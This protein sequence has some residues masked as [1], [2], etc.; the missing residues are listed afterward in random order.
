MRK[1]LLL[2]AVLTF[3]SPAL[4]RSI[5]VNW[6]VLD[7]VDSAFASAP[8][9]SDATEWLRRTLP[10]VEIHNGFIRRISSDT[11]FIFLDHLAE[12]DITVIYLP[13]DPNG[14]M[15]RY[16]PLSGGRALVTMNARKLLFF[17]DRHGLLDR[18][19]RILRHEF[20]HAIGLVA[21]KDHL[22]VVDGRHC[23][24]PKCLLHG[25]ARL[26]DLFAGFLPGAFAKYQPDDLCPLCKRDLASIWNTTPGP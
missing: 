1:V 16:Y 18:E 26:V 24:D 15:G 2:I 3:A 21:G 4:A 22:E 9:R 19:K 25:R 5:T 8:V 12:R 23:T 13:V 17:A 6:I 7:G 14:A 20:A 10:N 11:S